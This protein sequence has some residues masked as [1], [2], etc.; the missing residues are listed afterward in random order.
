MHP[1]PDLEW[2]VP[3]YFFHVFDGKPFMDSEGSVL[4]GLPAARREAIGVASDLLRSRSDDFW[5]GGAWHLDATDEAGKVLFR[6]MFNAVD[7]TLPA[8]C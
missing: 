3:R 7:C 5:H 1:C 8:L 2:D 4:P 6:L